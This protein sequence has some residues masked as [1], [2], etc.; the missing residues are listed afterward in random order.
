M[1][2]GGIQI[3]V[4]ESKQDISGLKRVG[5]W[6][7]EVTR[8]KQKKGKEK[9]KACETAHLYL[10]PTCTLTFS[11]LEQVDEHMDTGHHIMLPEKECVYDIIQTQWAATT[12]SIK[13]KSQDW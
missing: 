3:K 12:T 5:E 13:R 8:R 10:E 11:T 6:S 7:Q 4:F 9:S 1:S 2:L